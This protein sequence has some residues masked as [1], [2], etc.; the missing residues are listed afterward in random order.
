MDPPGG[1][2]RCAYS[3]TRGRGKTS[4]T[5]RTIWGWCGW[6]IQDEAGSVNSRRAVCALAL[7]LVGAGAAAAPATA[8]T[9]VVPFDAPTRP[10]SSADGFQAAVAAMRTTGGTI[11]LQPHRYTRT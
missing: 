11:V 7:V 5:G 4:E 6:A 8:G 10:V 3:T 9:P 2:V 1:P